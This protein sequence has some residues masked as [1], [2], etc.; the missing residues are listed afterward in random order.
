MRRL[1]IILALLLCATQAF[2]ADVTLK[3]DPMPA[4]Q[5]WEK[6]RIYEMVGTAY[7]L[8]AEVAGS[9]TQATI[10]N[11]PIGTHVY[12]AR[13]YQA[14]LESPDSNTAS[15]SF[16]PSS[17]MNFV[18]VASIGPNGAVSIRALSPEQ[19]AREFLQ[20]G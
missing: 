18:I 16:G 13:A 11:V 1:L 19:F 17:P 8:K 4:G 9:A 12:I 3:W 7:S 5:A 2:A 15:K 20:R 10:A 6:V 14:T